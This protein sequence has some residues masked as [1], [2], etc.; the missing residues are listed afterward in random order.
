MLVREE[1]G[2]LTDCDELDHLKKLSS[3]ALASIE[4]FCPAV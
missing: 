3:S 2:L 1:Y 4:T